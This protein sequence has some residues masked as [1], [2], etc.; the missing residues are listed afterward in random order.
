VWVGFPEE[1]P[2]RG[3]PGGGHA[4]GDPKMGPMEGITWSVLWTGSHFEGPLKGAAW[5]RWS[6]VGF[7]GVPW[8]VSLQGVHSRGPQGSRGVSS[9]GSLEGSSGGVPRRSPPAV[10]K[11]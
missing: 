10:Y 2:C 6:P 8:R 3:L 5:R 4:E 9:R 7:K 1:V 11:V